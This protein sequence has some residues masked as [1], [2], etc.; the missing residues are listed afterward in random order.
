MSVDGEIF[1]QK[2]L[3]VAIKKYSMIYIL[4]KNG[5]PIQVELGLS[6]LEIHVDQHSKS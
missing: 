6:I 2:K 3:N 4:L 1:C 5:A